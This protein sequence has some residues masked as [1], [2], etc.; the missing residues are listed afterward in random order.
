MVNAGIVPRDPIPGDG[1]L[2]RFHVQ[3]D[4]S[5]SRNGWAVLHLDCVPSGAFGSWKLGSFHTWCSK[6]GRE[7]SFAEQAL[8]AERIEAARQQRLSEQMQRQDSARRRAVRIWRQATPASPHHKYLIDKQIEPNIARQKGGSLVLPIVGF[9]KKLKS[10][11]FIKPDGSKL[12][13]SGGQKRGCVIPIQ[14]QPETHRILICEGFATG[15]SLAGMDPE[16]IVLAAID[17]GNLKVVAVATRQMWPGAEIVL[18]ADSDEVGL[19]KAKA[20]ALA[21]GGLLAVPEFP[22]NS[23]GSDFNDLVNMR[24]RNA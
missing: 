2:H 5:G 4:K 13:L 9:D 11:Q 19:A 10:L 8:Q 15:V 16:S 14:Q 1:Q 17:A 12:L 6:T 3:G 20:A 24:R 21:A 23:T 18:C 22:P 7:L